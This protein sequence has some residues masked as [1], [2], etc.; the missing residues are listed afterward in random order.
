MAVL[1]SD[2]RSSLTRRS[3]IDDGKSFIAS[4]QDLAPDG[5]NRI[6]KAVVILLRRSSSFFPRETEED[7]EGGVLLLPELSTENFFVVL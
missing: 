5:S 6:L 1:A 4:S 7:F 2:K 3:T